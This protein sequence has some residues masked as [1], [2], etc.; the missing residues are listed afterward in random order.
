V[1]IFKIIVQAVIALVLV[2][3]TGPA[4]AASGG[5]RPIIIDTYPKAVIFCSLGDTSCE[6]NSTPSPLGDV[7][8]YREGIVSFFNPLPDTASLAGGVA[9]FGSGLWVAPGFTDTAYEALFVSTN[10]YSSEWGFAINFYAP[11][12]T[13][14]SPHDEDPGT[15]PLF[16]VQVLPID[17]WSDG[18]QVAF[19]Y[20][21]APPIG[22]LIGYNALDTSAAF[23]DK[24]PLDINDSSFVLN[25]PPDQWQA[26]PSSV[27]NAVYDA[28]APGVPE[29]SAWTMLILGFGLAGIAVRR[30]T[31]EAAL[32]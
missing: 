1:S 20:S 28:A 19:A 22:S 15:T 8:I 26:L 10:S 7:Y 6:S 11:G 16:Q 25:F 27:F 9:S 5:G 30:R 24:K 31:R 23:S 13:V 14:E 32:A 18:W 17:F 3:G 21:G 29:P 12:T 4:W 2:G